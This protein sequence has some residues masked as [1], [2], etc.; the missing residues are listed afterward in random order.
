[1]FIYLPTEQFECGSL[2]AYLCFVFDEWQSTAFSASRVHETKKLRN[3]FYF[4]YFFSVHFYTGPQNARRK[5]CRMRGW[6]TTNCGDNDEYGKNVQNEILLPLGICTESVTMIVC[7]QRRRPKVTMD[8]GLPAS[9]ATQPK[10]NFISY[11]ICL[12]LSLGKYWLFTLAHLIAGSPTPACINCL[13]F[14]HIA[15]YGEI[16]RLRVCE[17]PPHVRCARWWQERNFTLNICISHQHRSF[18]RFRNTRGP[19]ANVCVND[20]GFHKFDVYHFNIEISNET[21]NTRS[22]REEAQPQKWCRMKSRPLA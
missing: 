16:V 18:D 19:P 9:C 3:V 12:W 20:I 11:F 8:D 13:D 5:S 6:T 10:F 2:R 17:C 4:F 22:Q 7:T 14:G 15:M 1:M 21:G